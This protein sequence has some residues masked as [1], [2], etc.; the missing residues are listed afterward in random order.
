[1]D[2]LVRNFLLN[3]SPSLYPVA[4]FW[5]VGCVCVFVCVGN[6]FLISSLT[7]RHAHTWSTHTNAL[8]KKGT[9]KPEPD[10]ETPEQFSSVSLEGFLFLSVWR[11]KVPFN[12][13]LTNKFILSSEFMFSPSFCS[14]GNN[15][16]RCSYFF[17]PCWYTAGNEEGFYVLCPV[18]VRWLGLSAFT[19]G[20]CGA[21]GQG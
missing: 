4:W 9:E 18:W 7:Y 20:S 8:A 17:E 5:K 13:C 21:P 3:F 14:V 2:Q 16:L 6:H 11:R 15:M 19:H 1:M 10:G 12:P